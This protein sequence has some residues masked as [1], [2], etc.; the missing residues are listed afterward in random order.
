M[1]FCW[2]KAPILY[3]IFLLLNLHVTRQLLPWLQ[4]RCPQLL[5]RCGLITALRVFPLLY[6]LILVY[7]ISAIVFNQKKKKVLYLNYDAIEKWQLSL[8][9]L[10]QHF[11]SLYENWVEILMSTPEIYFVN[12]HIK[13][14]FQSKNFEIIV[15][16]Y[17]IVTSKHDFKVKYFQNNT[18]LKN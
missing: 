6:W 9:P 15:F 18:N 7:K 5:L 10:S 17:K 2:S 1:I 4:R 8:P 11:P 14:C 16:K 13:S 12:T 3:V